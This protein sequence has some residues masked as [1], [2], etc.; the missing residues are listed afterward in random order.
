MAALSSTY[1][2]SL[3]RVV[4][5]VCFCVRDGASHLFHCLISTSHH[6]NSLLLLSSFQ[7]IHIILI[8][9]PLGSIGNFIDKLDILH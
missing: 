2:V 8:F 6:L 5:Q 9:H 4:V 7:A 3:A 1:A